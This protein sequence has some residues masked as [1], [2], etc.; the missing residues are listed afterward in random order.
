MELWQAPTVLV[1]HL[2]RFAVSGLSRSKLDDAIEFPLRGLDLTGY[3][4]DH[5]MLQL[6]ADVAECVVPPVYDLFA[7]AVSATACCKH[8]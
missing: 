8:R 4:Q 2:K 5:S 6:E 7:V 3:V 1:V